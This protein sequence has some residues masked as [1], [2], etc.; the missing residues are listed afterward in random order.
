MSDTAPNGKFLQICTTG[1]D[2]SAWSFYWYLW[3]THPNGYQRYQRHLRPQNL[4]PDQYPY[5]GKVRAA[6]AQF[7]HHSSRCHPRNETDQKRQEC[8]LALARMQHDKPA[9]SKKL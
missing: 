8:E 1:K 2:P 6:R 7:V 3:N 4:F 9:K 5:A